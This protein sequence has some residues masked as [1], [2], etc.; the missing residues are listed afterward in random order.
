MPLN[1]IPNQPL[2]RNIRPTDILSCDQRQYCHPHIPT[3]KLMAQFKQSPC[4]D[5]IVCDS[6]FLSLGNGDNEV[7]TDPDFSLLEVD[8]IT[9]G[10]FGGNANGWTLQTGWAYNSGHVTKS[11]T[12]NTVSIL[13][14]LQTALIQTAIYE[15]K[16]TISNY[17]GSGTVQAAIGL[18]A[19]A[20]FGTQV[21][22]NGTYTQYIKC[23]SSNASFEIFGTA[24]FTGDIDTISLK[25]IASS[26][27]FGFWYLNASRQA[28]SVPGPGS[29][30][31]TC[32]GVITQPNTDYV[33]EIDFDASTS[34]GFE[35]L[36][37]NN[38]SN[39]TSSSGGTISLTVNSGN[40]GTNFAVVPSPTAVLVINSI[41]VKTTI[42]SGECWTFD[43]TK[44][45]LSNEKLCKLIG[46]SDTLINT[47]PVDAG[48]YY[49]F[50]ITIS[51]RTSGSITPTVGNDLGQL[52]NTNGTFTQYF[53][54][55]ASGFLSIFADSTFDG[56]V[57]VV[58]LF[59]LKR[60]Y[61][62]KLLDLEGNEVAN[63]TP[64]YYR[65]F[66]TVNTQM[67]DLE[68]GGDPI[69]FGCY[70]LH[71]F[72]QCELQYSEIIGDGRMDNAYGK[73]WVNAVTG[74][75]GT[76]TIS[77]G[78]MIFDYS[79]VDPGQLIGVVNCRQ[80]LPLCTKEDPLIP[81][82]PH[83]YKYEFDILENTD[84]ANFK[85]TLS[86]CRNYNYLASYPVGHYVGYFM[87]LDPTTFYN[88]PDDSPIYPVGIPV[89]FTNN[90]TP[91]RI[92]IDN[93]TLKRIEP[94]DSSYVSECIIYGESFKDT[95]LISAECDSEQMGFLFYN[96][97]DGTEVFKLTQRLYLRAINPSYP[98]DTDDY[99][100]SDGTKS[101]NYG[102]SEKSYTI[103]TDAID[104]TSIDA[105]A[106]QRI[107]QRFYIGEDGSMVQWIPL[108]SDLV[109]E[110]IKNGDSVLAAVRFE[111]QEKIK[112]AKFFRNS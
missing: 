56:C 23:S 102:K 112:G 14:A 96:I 9:N 73:Y 52:I 20:S 57:S 110:W 59:E 24:A 29:R 4:N 61:I 76:L 91:G 94:Y 80:G 101:R 3:D 69:P 98:E 1:L 109:P 75:S 83:N 89:S 41:S 85:V 55:T 12:A 53:L 8:Q 108:P 16:F 92:R 99:L 10:T 39:F 48:T 103:L 93:V 30:N 46:F 32:L 105:L 88:A 86:V 17:G 6:R 18:G 51:G 90:Q 42:A 11:A 81:R 111:V 79:A 70:Q 34:G 78:E 67:D 106:K 74:G 35:V 71:A 68:D 95:K 72:D 37:G 63:V 49:Q 65:D 7:I 82:G 66:V 33:V 84:P 58:L 64:K 45:I 26:W 87:G 38:F 2:F 100:F 19:G 60:D 25:Q 15:V 77:A 40:S 36:V 47:V 107:C 43:N 50:K 62:F 21:S 31:L 54:P 13:Q 5:S 97:E 104:E 28:V 27:T 22:A 44:W